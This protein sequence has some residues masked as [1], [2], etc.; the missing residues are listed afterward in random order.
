MKTIK[1]QKILLSSLVV[2]CILVSVTSCKVI[3]TNQLGVKQTFGKMSDKV[4]KPG[5]HGYFPGATKITVFDCKILEI[6]ERS[7]FAT[8]DGLEITAKMSLLYHI[9]P[10]S[11]KMIYKKLEDDFHEMYVGNLFRSVIREEIVQYQAKDVVNKIQVLQDSITAILTPMLHK[12][13]FIID[14][15]II[16]DIDLPEEINYAI[17]EKVKA[18]QNL[19]QR[20]VEME[21]ERQNIN[22][23]AE[24]AKILNASRLAQAQQET[25]III[26][27]Q[28]AE[29]ERLL[30]EAQ[31][32]AEITI[33]QE[34]AEAERLLIEAKAKKESQ[35]IVNKS[36]TNNQLELKRIEA[37]EK[38]AS[39]PNSKLIITD[40]KTQVMFRTDGN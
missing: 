31:R 20:Q 38:L 14:K 12:Y 27:K 4:L 35:E 33:I 24:K 13:G 36:L 11:V 6:N 7:A 18:E 39:S 17:K 1:F 23:D 16:T 32:Q 15:T 9:N 10:D 28:K 34:K 37:T 5:A 3:N 2:S 21:I 40:G 8:H 26:V 19:K 25:D 30:L 22:F 29:S